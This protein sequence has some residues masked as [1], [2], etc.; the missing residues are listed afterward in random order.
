MIKDSKV[1]V[2][3]IVI[4]VMQLMLS[5]TVFAHP[6]SNNETVDEHLKNMVIFHKNKSFGFKNNNRLSLSSLKNGIKFKD[7]KVYVPSGVIAVVFGLHTYWE[8]DTKLT[9][10]APANMFIVDF[11]NRNIYYNG[12]QLI[13]DLDYIYANDTYYLP[14]AI[15][16]GI[17]GKDIYVHNDLLIMSEEGYKLD[18]DNKVLIEEINKYFFEPYYY[19]RKMIRKS[20]FYFNNS[21]KII[22]QPEDNVVQI[23]GEIDDGPYSVD[24]GFAM[25]NGLFITNLDSIKYA[26][27]IYV[28]TK[29]KRKVPAQGVVKY[30][31]ETGLAII[32]ATQPEKMNPFYIAKIDKDDSAVDIIVVKNIEDF[33]SIPLDK[34]ISI[35][36]NNSSI[37]A[38]TIISSKRLIRYGKPLV[39][40]SN[41]VSNSV[42][43]NERES[44][45]E[46]TLFTESINEWV[47]ELSGVPFSKIKTIDIKEHMK[48][49]FDEANTKVKKV[50]EKAFVA[51]NNNDSRLYNS[52]LD[53]NHREYVYSSRFTNPIYN[54]NDFKYH[55]EKINVVNNY[56]SEIALEVIYTMTNSEDS[57]FKAFR[58]KGLF[59]V[60][61]INNS[62]KII[63]AHE[64][65]FD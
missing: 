27:S 37:L 31:E 13:G 12:K 55:I 8:S 51:L 4:L 20:P 39:Y 49:K 22:D 59:T 42:E 26:D 9:Y 24:I 53:K 17:L 15:F 7:N 30:N 11:A 65:F 48:A 3:L 36:S 46:L 62:F 29:D 64:T 63:T 58:A 47:K 28:V 35:S 61:E 45:F 10:N 52:L 2:A 6:Y 25:G 16:T 14:L 44:N 1:K 41:A 60:S 40:I 57:S 34:I 32:K 23:L 19:E 50:I 43:G 21:L 33:K 5:S 54:R 18:I 56:G 38:S